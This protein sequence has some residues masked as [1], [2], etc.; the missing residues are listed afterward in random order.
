MSDVE[1][2]SKNELITSNQKSFAFHVIAYTDEVDVDGKQ[3]MRTS[4][5][6]DHHR[7]AQQLLKALRDQSIVLYVE[8]D[9]KDNSESDIRTCTLFEYQS[10]P[11]NKKVVAESHKDA[12]IVLTEKMINALA[13]YY[14]EAEELPA[15]ALDETVEAIEQIILNSK[16]L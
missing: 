16:T 11:R 13:Y 1:K 2:Q 6:K 10:D 3:K 9:P 12:P 8:I 15:F 5:K 14:K 7:G 4:F